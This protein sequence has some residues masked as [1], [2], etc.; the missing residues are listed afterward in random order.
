MP[1]TA[2]MEVNCVSEE[3]EKIEKTEKNCV[4]VCGCEKVCTAHSK[5]DARLL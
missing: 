3:K 4:Y 1:K 5:R 2:I